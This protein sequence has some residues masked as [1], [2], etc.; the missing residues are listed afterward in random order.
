MADLLKPEYKGRIDTEPYLAGFDVLVAKSVWGYD[1]TAAFVKACS[2]Q[3]GGLVRCGATEQVASGQIPAL[4]IDCGGNEQNL[5]KYKDVL[6]AQHHP[7]RGDA[8]LQLHLHP[9]ERRASECRHPVRAVHLVARGPAND[10]IFALR[11]RSRHLSRRLF[12]SG[13]GRAG[14]EGV[15]FQDVTTS[16]WD[17]HEE[18]D[19]DLKKLIKIVTQQ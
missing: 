14:E 16:W 12:A 1:K 3:V 18:I 8:A 9:D 5:P 11:H 7:R 13:H 17:S 10:P 19:N 4:A 2:A 15:K 6:G